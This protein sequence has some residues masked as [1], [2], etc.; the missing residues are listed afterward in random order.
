MYP[1]LLASLL[2][3]ADEPK[4]IPELDALRLENASLRL[5]LMA[6]ELEAIHRERNEL[7][8]SV[9]AAAKIDITECSIDPVKRTVSRK[10]LPPK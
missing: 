8:K 10:P 2:A 7:I 9:C 1:I 5:D 6:K 4:A 3:F